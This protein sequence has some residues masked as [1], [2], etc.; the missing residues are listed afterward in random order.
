MPTTVLFLLM[1]VVVFIVACMAYFVYISVQKERK[2]TIEES[3]EQDDTAHEIQKSNYETAIRLMKRQKYQ[4]AMNLLATLSYKD[5][6]ALYTA[7]QEAVNGK[8]AGVINQLR[9]TAFAIPK[10]TASIKED[11]F[12][13]CSDL[14]SITIPKGVTD[15]GDRA[16][17]ACS[18]LK[19][20][21]IPDGVS[22]IGDRAFYACPRLTSITIPDSVASIGDYAFLGSY[23]EDY[24][25][26]IH[27]HGTKQRWQTI[28]S[29]GEYDTL[30]YVVYCSDGIIYG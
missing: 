27:F 20:I 5:S 19:S 10:G 14:T 11:A 9:L 24:C 30:R 7:C 4:E 8:Y 18:A 6:Y 13:W 25:V 29:Y 3:I 15:I 2:R 22:G 1:L 26:K 12:L 16:F 23:S 21:V 17:Y 28:K